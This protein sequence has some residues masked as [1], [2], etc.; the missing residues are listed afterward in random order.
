M[1]GRAMTTNKPNHKSTLNATII[2]FPTP[3]KA[4]PPNPE[5]SATPNLVATDA[6]R[7]FSPVEALW[8]KSNLYFKFRGLTYRATIDPRFGVVKRL[9]VLDRK[10]ARNIWFHFLDFPALGSPEPK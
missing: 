1:K 9:V 2:P 3:A 7:G 8:L 6:A 5:L 4:T 10:S